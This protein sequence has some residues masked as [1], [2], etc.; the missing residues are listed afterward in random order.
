MSKIRYAI[1]YIGSQAYKHYIENRDFQKA[2]IDNRTKNG[3]KNI[4]FLDGSKVLGSDY[5]EC[6]V[7]GIH[8]TDMGSQRIANAL[9]IAIQDILSQ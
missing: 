3:D 8:P 7:D 2:L 9:I 4:Y 1:D 5:F 6:T